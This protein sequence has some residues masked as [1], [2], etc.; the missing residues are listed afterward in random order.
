MVVKGQLK[1]LPG[2]RARTDS[3]LPKLDEVLLPMAKRGDTWECNGK[4]SDGNLVCTMP[5]RMQD[6]LIMAD[7]S[8]PQG[9]HAFV[10]KPWGELVGLVSPTG[11]LLMATSTERFTGLFEA[12]EIPLEGT[13][14]AE[15]IYDGRFDDMIK[16]TYQ[17]YGKD[18]SNPSYFKGIS[19]N[20]SSLN[21]FKVKDTVIEVLDANENEIRFIIRN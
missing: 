19:Y 10:F 4:T 8:R 12:V 21:T 5:Q 18:L 13:S 15:I 7:G 16:I 17:E 9:L 11:K 1:V 2:F 3:F 6:Q 20:L 14:R